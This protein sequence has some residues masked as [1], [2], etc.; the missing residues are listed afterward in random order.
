MGPPDDVW[1]SCQID[2]HVKGP[3]IEGQL[4]A[5]IP[6]GCLRRLRTATGTSSGEFARIGIWTNGSQRVV[7]EIL[8]GVLDLVSKDAKQLPWF[9]RS[10]KQ[11]SVPVDYC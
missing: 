6:D 2:R 7:Q 4:P 11:I 9:D 8:V 3:E 10:L 5:R 1:D